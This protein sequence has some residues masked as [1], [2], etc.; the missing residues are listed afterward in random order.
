[1]TASHALDQ[2][3]ILRLSTD[4]TVQELGGSE[5]GVVLNLKSGEM[6]TVNETAIAFLQSLNGEISIAQAAE[7]IVNDF[8]VTRDVLIADL[9]ELSN[10][11]RHEGL[12]SGR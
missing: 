1:M 9:I 2:T 8:E 3:A 5:G 7:K 12:I 10:Q 11:L 4:V 6:Y